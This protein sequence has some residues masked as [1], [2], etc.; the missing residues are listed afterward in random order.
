MKLMTKSQALALFYEHAC[1]IDD[2]DA[3]SVDVAGR[4]LGYEAVKDATKNRYAS[5]WE[6]YSCSLGNFNYLTEY[7]F[8]RAVTYCNIKKLMEEEELQKK[9]ARGR[10]KKGGKVVAMGEN[11]E[12]NNAQ[13]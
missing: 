6:C 4:L 3:M 9:K 5:A 10:R 8:L 1:L 12:G 2:R 7:G 13:M 11:R